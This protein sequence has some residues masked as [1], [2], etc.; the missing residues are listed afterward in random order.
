M[1]FFWVADKKLFTPG[2]LTSSLTV[3]QAMLRDL[4][5]RDQEFISTI[6]W[7]RDQLLKIANVESSTWTAVP[8][9]GSGTFAVEAVLQTSIPRKNGKVSFKNVL[10]CMRV[11]NCHIIRLWFWQMVPMAKE[12]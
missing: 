8:M 7:I 3:K 9:Q 12:W 1:T 6:Q 11:S 10:P 4:G 5:S 2:P